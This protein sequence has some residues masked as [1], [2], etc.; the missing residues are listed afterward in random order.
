VKSRD[1]R[2]SISSNLQVLRNPEQLLASGL[3][4]MRVSLSGFT[5][6]IYELGHRGGDIEVV[7]HNMRRL[8]AAKASTGAGTT[9]EVLY[10]RYRDNA[11][12]IT[13]MA[14][15]SNWLGFEFR[16]I[17]AYVTVVEKVL[18]IR[19]GNHEP[20]DSLVLDRLAVPL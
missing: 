3:D 18:A 2:C 14:S 20:E 16:T 9:I 6:R 15:F 5:Q 7:K 13:P 11:A 12:E 17:L 10:H 1:L 19:A 4:L 8:A